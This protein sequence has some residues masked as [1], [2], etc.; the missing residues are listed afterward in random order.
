M[1]KPVANALQ[2]KPE[3]FAKPFISIKKLKIILW[4]LF[5]P[6]A[7]LPPAKN[8]KNWLHLFLLELLLEL[9][10]GEGAKA[11]AFLDKRG[12]VT[13]DD[14]KAVALDILR[15]RMILSFEAEAEEIDT[16][17]VIKKVLS[18]IPTP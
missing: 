17:K 4:I 1:I 14:V 7:N 3:E 18:S 6:R 8:A 2:L 16:T 10:F 15:H 9:P 11:R 12:F 13:P 5:L